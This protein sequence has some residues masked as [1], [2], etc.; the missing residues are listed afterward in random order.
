M[1]MCDECLC[2]SCP[3]CFSEICGNCKECNCC[4]KEIINLTDC[5]QHDK[6]LNKKN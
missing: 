1:F 4:D 2:K 6:Y 5:I 3:V